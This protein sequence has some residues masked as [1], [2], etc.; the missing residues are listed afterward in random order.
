MIRN[1]RSKSA[2]ATVALAVA[3]AG[4]A[5]SV[6]VLIPRMAHAQLL[7]Q[8]LGDND[9]D[10]NDNP[11]QPP[12]NGTVWDEKRL[13]RLDRN[14]RRVQRSVDG[15]EV[16][17]T[18]PVLLGPDPEVQALQATA[19]NLSSRL[20]D[21]SSTITHL[22][23]QLEDTQHQD[24]LLEQRVSA[25]MART[26]DLIRRANDA[27][28]HLNRIDA[29]LAPPPPPP[30]SQGTAESDFAQALDLMNSGRTDDAER[31]F[32]AF[33]TTWPEATQLPEAWFRLGEVRMIKE[34]R[35][36]AIAALATALKGWPKTPWAPQATIDL[37]SALSD[38]HRPKEAC[39]ALAKFDRS[40]TRLA[41]GQVST[42][43]ARLEARVRC[44]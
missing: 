4:A 36:G 10:N 19:G 25:L 20:D 21:N 18:P 39:L 27:E 41:D 2:F 38:A 17:A 35:G 14:V 1:A 30:P 12:T 7:Q 8:L 29:A 13:E 32:A 43:A 40:Y 24:Q 6:T 16:K 42:M 3:L 44:R 9:D 34:D 26:D 5:A 22:T 28:T 37:A 11:A 23:G 33:T 15:I 31:A